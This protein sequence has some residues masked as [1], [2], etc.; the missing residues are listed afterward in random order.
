[1]HAQSKPAWWAAHSLGPKP[2]ANQW[3]RPWKSQRPSL[4]TLRPPF[5]SPGVVE[6]LLGQGIEV[7]V[8]THAQRPVAAVISLVKKGR[9]VSAGGVRVRWRGQLATRPSRWLTSSSESTKPG[10]ALGGCLGLGGAI[11][12]GTAI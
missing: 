1:M 6:V 10:M 11:V 12:V 5:G 9:V 2:T 7:L 8:E 4:N 3:L